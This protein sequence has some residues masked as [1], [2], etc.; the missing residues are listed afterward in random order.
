MERRGVAVDAVLARESLWTAA[1]SLAFAK[2]VLEVERD[3]LPLVAMDAW[4]E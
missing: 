1:A 3:L 2:G 4:E